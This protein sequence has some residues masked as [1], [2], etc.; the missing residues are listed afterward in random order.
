MERMDFPLDSRRNTRFFRPRHRRA[1]TC[2]PP[3]F[4]IVGR[5]KI[6]AVDESQLPTTK[7]SFHESKVAGPSSACSNSSMEPRGWLKA[8]LLKVEDRA[9]K[10]RG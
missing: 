8:L 5:Q 9:Q 4:R 1:S 7:T 6:A 3:R 10:A 2:L